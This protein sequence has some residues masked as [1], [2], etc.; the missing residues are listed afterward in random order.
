MTNPCLSGSYEEWFQNDC[1]TVALNSGQD[2][3]Y[4]L[5]KIT[6]PENQLFIP[7]I[8]QLST[9][10]LNNRLLFQGLVADTCN[11]S[12]NG[13]YCREP[14]LNLCGQYSKSD[15]FNPIIE[16]FCGCYL[17]ADNYDQTL[18][19][20][21]DRVCG[22]SQPIPYYES[23]SQLNY[24]TCNTSVC[25]IDNFTLIS[26]GSSV[27]NITFTQACPNCTI[28]GCR[29]IISDINLIASDS[30]LGGL[31][32][33]QDCE[34]GTTCYESSSGIA[35][36]VPCEQYLSTFGLPTSSLIKEEQVLSTYTWALLASALIIL[37]LIITIAI[38]V[39]M[40]NDQTTIVKLGSSKLKS[41]S[42]D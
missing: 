21:C 2:F 38:A 30:R 39:F 34:Q 17:S 14:L 26:I 37:L 24:Q 27:D 3:Y 11:E 18:P 28:T 36:E 33:E 8:S 9:E 25:L 7:G 41:T 15:L 35:Q 29:C 1:N 40:S 42:Q 13:R 16:R 22:N 31:N 10:E 12:S 32:I 6:W 23:S 19:R 4:Q 5:F 20:P